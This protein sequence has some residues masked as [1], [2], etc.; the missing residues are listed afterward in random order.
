MKQIIEA[1]DLQYGKT[2][3]VHLPQIE[4]TTSASSL[5]SSVK[6]KINAPLFLDLQ[7]GNGTQVVTSWDIITPSLG[8]YST[9]NFGESPNVV[10]ESGLS[11]ILMD[12]VP[13]KYYLSETA[14]QGV[15]RRSEKRGKPLNELF[16]KALKQQIRRW[17]TYGVPFLIHNNS[18]QHS[19]IFDAR[20][21][22]DGY[23][24]PT[25][26][27]DHNNRISDYTTCVC[28][29]YIQN[30]SGDNICGT[31]DANYHK[32][33]GSRGNREREL[34]IVGECSSEYEEPVQYAVR[35]LT[36]LECGRLQGMPDWWLDDVDGSD[37]KKYKLC[38]NGMALPNAIYIMEGIASIY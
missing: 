35:R 19:A 33:C 11:Q 4:E 24:V 17:R 22:G 9:L 36:P 2:S 3:Q 18:H 21:N 7:K 13:L 12:N 6:L 1:R 23:I 28:E 29:T 15:L 38:G 16:Y 37:L 10:E 5:R 25:I 8:E 34:I 31:L 26:T 27:G 32:G 20:G 30:S 14:C